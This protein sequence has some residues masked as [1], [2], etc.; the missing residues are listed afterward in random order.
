LILGG[1][2]AVMT[3]ALVLLESRMIY[4]PSRY[5]VG[6]WDAPKREGG[7]VEDVYIETSDGVR[8]HGWYLPVADAR[9]TVLFFHGNAGNLSDRYGWG[10]DLT[11]LGVNVLMVDYRGYG[12]SEGSPSEEG[13]YADAEAAWL[14]LVNHRGVSPDRLVA[15]G[16]SLG[17][18]PAC[19]LAVRR[20]V[21][22]LILQSTFSSARDMAGEMFPFLPVGPLVRTRFDTAQK[23]PNVSAPKLVVHSRDDEMIPYRMAERVYERAHEPKRFVSYEGPG[24]N[25][26]IVVQRRALLHELD[27]F[28]R[29]A[30]PSPAHQ[31]PDPPSDP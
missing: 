8:L 10:Q 3:L 25:D 20:P 21:A 14:F 28:L 13:L 30:L 12:K 15:Y 5:P 11:T 7:L 19:E 22:G 31:E 24:H 1:G 4:Y 9:G 17:G 23:I 2:V 29:Q 26:L 6:D 16:I 27:L 18:A